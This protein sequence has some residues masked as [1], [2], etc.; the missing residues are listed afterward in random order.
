MQ[1]KLLILSRENVKR[2]SLGNVS[3]TMSDKKLKA[4]LGGYASGTCATKKAD[5]SCGDRN[6]SKTEAL[7]WLACEDQVN[8][9][10]YN[11]GYWCCDSCST[12]QWYIDCWG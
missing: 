6:I 3:E 10:G 12:T 5:G 2:F 1:K 7:F 11:G 8:G 9:T 4:V